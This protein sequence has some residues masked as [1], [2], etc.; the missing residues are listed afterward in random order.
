MGFGLRVEG[1]SSSSSSCQT[2]TTALNPTNP[3]HRHEFWE[4]SPELRAEAHRQPDDSADVAARDGERHEEH[5]LLQQIEGKKKK[6]KE[7]DV[8]VASKMPT[9]LL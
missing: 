6:K 4:A 3:T 5:K 8:T 1:S 7:R 2:L 9:V